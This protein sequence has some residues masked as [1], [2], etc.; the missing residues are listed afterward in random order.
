MY[1]IDKKSV[2]EIYLTQFRKIICLQIYSLEMLSFHRVFYK[3]NLDGGSQ[4]EIYG[5]NHPHNLNQKYI[6]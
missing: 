5:L 4:G 3:I 2:L 1:I 6:C